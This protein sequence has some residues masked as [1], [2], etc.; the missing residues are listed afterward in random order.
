[1]KRRDLHRTGGVALVIF[2]ACA[3]ACVMACV[4]ACA[5]RSL[6]ARADGR[7]TED[8]AWSVSGRFDGAD[9]LSGLACLDDRDC[10]AASDELRSV[11]RFRI[12]PAVPNGGRIIVGERIELLHEGDELDAEG[13]CAMD[14][15]YYV[16]GSHG[17]SR[18][19]KRQANRYHLVRIDPARDGEPA[20]TA[21]TSLLPLI[22]SHAEIA[23]FID[24]GLQA[25]GINIEAIACKDRTLYVGFRAPSRDGKAAVLIVDAEQAFSASRRSSELRW[26]EL[27]E[28]VGIRGMTESDDGLLLLTGASSI[29]DDTRR[30]TAE[31]R[32]PALYRWDGRST[33]AQR[34]GALPGAP[35]KPEG[36]LL[37]ART[38][39]GY[40]VLVL[41]DSEPNGKPLEYDVGRTTAT[42]YSD[43]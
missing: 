27:G 40:R 14:G 29:D 19:G 6:A 42:S 7:I 33:T 13:V 12:E 15:R 24:A 43:D 31:H 11:Q 1:M 18:K 38:S 36:L 22:A 21:F 32:A 2:V 9:D 8:G 4:T 30:P 35:D 28:G 3:A 20:T 34:L 25:G 10:L 16:V 26:I 37:L 23:P 41:S 39:T 17:L 5:P